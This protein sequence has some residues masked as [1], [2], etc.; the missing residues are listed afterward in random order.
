M[1]PLIAGTGCHLFRAGRSYACDVAGF[2]VLVSSAW[3]SLCSESAG[4][5]DARSGVATLRDR[6]KT[7]VASLADTGQSET[8]RELSVMLVRG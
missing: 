6:S 8:E 7:R 3:L 2:V 4:T 5:V 1:V